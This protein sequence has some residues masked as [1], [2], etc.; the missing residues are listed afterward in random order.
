MSCDPEPRG[1]GIMPTGHAARA[2]FSSQRSGR[3]N[4]KNFLCGNPGNKSRPELVG[5]E[6][7]FNGQEIRTPRTHTLAFK[8]KVALA[9]LR[10]DKTMAELCNQSELHANQITQWKKQLLAHAAD[11]FEGGSKPVKVFDLAPLHAKIGQLTFE[12]DFLESALTKA[13][14]LRAKLLNRPRSQTS[15]YPISQT[16]Q[17]SPT[18]GVLPAPAGECRRSDVHA[19]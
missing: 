4:L 9:A 1:L 2:S 3:A 13:G 14:L 16:A 8:A 5:H 17:G 6:G 11:A 7:V 15:C 18:L 19:Y 10:E 12:N